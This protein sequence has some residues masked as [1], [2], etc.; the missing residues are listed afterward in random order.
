MQDRNNGE[1]EQIFIS[2]QSRFLKT[3]Y[4][5]TIQPYVNIT[6]FGASITKKE[7]NAKQTIKIKCCIFAWTW[8]NRTTGTGKYL[9]HGW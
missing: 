3:I 7:N 1:E 8:I 4:E 9:H 2:L 5:I 6:I